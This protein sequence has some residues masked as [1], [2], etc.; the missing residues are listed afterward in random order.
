MSLLDNLFKQQVVVDGAQP[1]QI[2][3]FNGFSNGS[4]F[5]SWMIDGLDIFDADVVR[6]DTTADP[7]TV[8]LKLVGM[9]TQEG[10]MKQRKI[11]VNVGPN[12]ITIAH[13]VGWDSNGWFVLADEAGFE[14]WPEVCVEAVWLPM[15]GDSP[16]GWR[17]L[18]VL[19]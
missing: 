4:P 19:S 14:M 15:A 6:I 13:L 16:A 9:N 5:V 12:P 10:E 1:L 2:A 8:F 18:G 17:L 11:L 3:T 7:G